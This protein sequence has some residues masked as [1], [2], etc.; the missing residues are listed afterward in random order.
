MV[1]NYD[2]W[3]HLIMNKKKEINYFVAVYLLSFLII[4]L[5]FITELQKFNTLILL[6]VL[7]RVFGLSAFFLISAQLMV[8]NFFEYFVSRYGGWVYKFHTYQGIV[9]YFLVVLHVLS[10]IL[11]DYISLG[12]KLFLNDIF[13]FC[14]LCET[15]YDFFISLGKLAFL[16]ISLSVIAGKF[17]SQIE[18]RRIWRYIHIS[19]Y[20]LYPIIFIHALK[21]GTDFF[22]FP[23]I[24][25]IFTVIISL[26]VYLKV[27]SNI[28]KNRLIKNF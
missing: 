6:N 2:P 18:L 10:K 20:L 7:Q 19:N 12:K 17:R 4:L 16:I 8:G 28:V 21:L 3:G 13:S 5:V 22:G 1:P 27:L 25:I 9:G 14:L 15:K 26:I 23:L 11:F 24:I